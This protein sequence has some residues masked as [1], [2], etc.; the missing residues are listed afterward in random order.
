MLSRLLNRRWIR[1]LAL[2]VTFALLA[3]VLWRSEDSRN[4]TIE[5]DQQGQNEPDGFVKDSR[6]LSFDKNGRRVV[7]IES[8]RIEQFEPEGLATMTSPSATLY[9]KN[10]G[11]P[12]H[13]TARN[14]TFHQPA[15]RLELSGDVTVVRPLSGKREA[16][17]TTEQLT[18]DNHSHTVFTDKPVLITE[19]HG[20]TAAVGMK[21]WI[22]DRIL[23]LNS[24]VKGEYA[25][26]RATYD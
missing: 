21:A 1:T 22:D 25:P 11:K 3:A 20:Q 12:W 6:Y 16:T 8:P 4:Q 19:D 15:D 10:S 23:E 26:L 7:M 24:Q 9:D 2:M 5:T 14:G 17:L 18:L 13:L